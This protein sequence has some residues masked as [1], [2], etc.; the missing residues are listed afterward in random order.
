MK[1]V[2]SVLL[3]I[4][5]SLETVFAQNKKALDAE[6]GFRGHKFGDPISTFTNMELLEKS[7]DG[8]EVF[9]KKTD[10][11]QKKKFNISPVEL[12][13]IHYS[14]YKDRFEGVI[15]SVKYGADIQDFALN[16]LEKLYGSRNE[17]EY[18]NGDYHWNGKNVSVMYYESNGQKKISYSSLELEKQL[19]QE[20]KSMRK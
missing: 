3:I 4:A 12:E 8:L 16:Q 17:Y 10:L 5:L 14:F 7:N 18:Y 6:N 15:V 19:T 2:L 13:R 1:K 9:Y 20:R 11:F